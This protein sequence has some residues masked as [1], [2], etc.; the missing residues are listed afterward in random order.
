VTRA[1]GFACCVAAA[2]CAAAAD[3]SLI[4]LVPG[5]AVTI[6]G[7]DA[8][9][10][11]DSALGRA[12]LGN[13]EQAAGSPL[14]ALA[15]AAGFDLRQDLMEAVVAVRSSADSDDPLILLRGRFDASRIQSLAAGRAGS[16]LRRHREVTLVTGVSASG[17]VR[18][19][20]APSP[21]LFVAGPLEDVQGAIDRWSGQP[22]PPSPIA[23]Q[24]DQLRSGSQLWLLSRQPVSALAS[25]AEDRNVSGVLQGDLFAAIEEWRVQVRLGSPI[26]VEAQAATQTPKDAAALAEVAQFL[27]TL[28][29]TQNTRAAAGQLLRAMKDFEASAEQNRAFLRFSVPDDQAAL[30]LRALPLFGAWGLGGTLPEA[31]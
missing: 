9:A 1:L 30:L 7:L 13:T 23:R 25:R 11:R 14:E 4:E 5:D 10:A 31:P 21:S 16:A 12:L 28:I 20:A 24:A 22:S 8:A 26:R 15:H 17:G 6:A 29:R 18:A 2:L 19:L 3:R 27:V